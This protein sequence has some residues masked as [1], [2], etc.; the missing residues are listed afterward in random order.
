MSIDQ[1]TPTQ[2]ALPV[3]DEAEARRL[4]ETHNMPPLEV[5]AALFGESTELAESVLR[6]IDDEESKLTK[7]HGLIEGR[8]RYRPVRMLK[9][10]ARKYQTGRYRNRD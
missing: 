9:N 2:R 3:V 10:Y 5:D 6:W 4:A 1:S 7:A 8:K